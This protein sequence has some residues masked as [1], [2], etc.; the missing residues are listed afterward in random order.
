MVQS[1]EASVTVFK[2][3]IKVVSEKMDLHLKKKD[4]EWVIEKI[5]IYDQDSSEEE[6]VEKKEKKP[7]I[8]K[9]G[10]HKFR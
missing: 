1:T 2:K 5:D 3:T 7:R 8:E 9:D 10:G 4:G 6:K